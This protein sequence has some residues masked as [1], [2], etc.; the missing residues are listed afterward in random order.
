MKWFDCDR[1]VGLISQQGAGPDVQAEASAVHG[2]DNRLRQGEK[3][4]FD[5]TLDSAGLRADNIHRLRA[6]RDGAV[7]AGS[8]EPSDGQALGVAP[9]DQA[10]RA[11]LAQPRHR[12]GPVGADGVR[13]RPVAAR[14]TY[15]ALDHTP[16]E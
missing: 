14:P 16:H 15:R 1:G 10:Q 6:G 9:P 5:I 8:A 7:P 11:A 2:S 13:A 12:V 4:L 3:V